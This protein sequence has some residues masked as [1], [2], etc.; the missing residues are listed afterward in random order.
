MKIKL[1]QLKQ[2]IR[3]EALGSSDTNKACPAC[4]E[5]NAPN[6]KKPINGKYQ[7]DCA[8]GEQYHGKQNVYEASNKK[9]L[10][11]G[12]ARITAEEVEAWK[13]GDYG[14]VSPPQPSLPG[15]DYSMGPRAKEAYPNQEDVPEDYEN[16]GTCGYDHAYDFP[17][18]SKEDL[19]SAISAHNLMGNKPY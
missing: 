2:I 6:D 4:G 19:L 15:L 7:Y 16:C 13:N 12:H 10:D 18:L 14:F 5:K 3:E 8:C 1:S 9:K 17:L 11:E